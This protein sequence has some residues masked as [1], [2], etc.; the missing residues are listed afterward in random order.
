M[1]H[2]CKMLTAVD[3]NLVPKDYV[4]SRG[5]R[6]NSQFR[7]YP[8]ICRTDAEATQGREVVAWR[9]GARWLEILSICRADVLP[10]TASPVTASEPDSQISIRAMRALIQQHFG[11]AAFRFDVGKETQS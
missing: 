10:V 8:F 5:A 4:T 6:K 11:F 3:D 7:H 9:D 2:R 1:K